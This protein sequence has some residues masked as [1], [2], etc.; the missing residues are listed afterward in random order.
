MSFY[1]YIILAYL[2]VLTGFNFYRSRKIKSQD[3]F[4]G[5]RPEPEV[6]GHG[7]HPDLHL[8]RLGH[9]HQ[10]RRIRVQGRVL[11]PLA[12]RR[13]PGSASS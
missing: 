12:R 2:L 8:D 10:R 1:L 5:R 9:V 7:L 11:G 13:A 4:H 6:A 3:D